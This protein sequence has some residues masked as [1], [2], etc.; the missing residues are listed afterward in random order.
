MEGSLRIL[1]RA[2]SLN[3]GR[4]T[5]AHGRVSSPPGIVILS[6]LTRTI[7]LSEYHAWLSNGAIN[8]DVPLL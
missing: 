6:H 1:L 5:S 2:A 8:P 4:L 3:V 7:G